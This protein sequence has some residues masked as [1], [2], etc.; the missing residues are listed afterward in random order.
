MLPEPDAAKAEGISSARLLSRL[1]Q[2]KSWE[3]YAAMSMARLRREL[4]KP[5]EAGELLAP[6]HGWFTKGFDTLYLREAK[7][8]L[9]TARLTSH[10]ETAS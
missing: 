5:R 10:F 2:T 1:Q 6:I 9:S 7:A 3:F 8:L 4:G